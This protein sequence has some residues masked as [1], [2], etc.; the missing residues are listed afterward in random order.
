MF[1]GIEIKSVLN[2][3]FDEITVARSVSF[4]PS[5]YDF[6]NTF[7]LFAHDEILFE[8][9]ALG[10]TIMKAEKLEPNIVVDMDS[11]LRKMMKQEWTWRRQIVRGTEDS[12]VWHYIKSAAP[13]NYDRCVDV[14]LAFGMEMKD[15]EKSIRT[16][17]KKKLIENKGGRIHLKDQTKIVDPADLEQEKIQE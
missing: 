6:L 4:D 11:K 15:A 12:M 1:I 13:L 7:D 3:R 16:L 5:F 8:K 10:Y 2:Q 14:L 9:M 17:V